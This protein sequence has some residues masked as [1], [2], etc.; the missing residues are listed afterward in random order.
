MNEDRITKKMFDINIKYELSW[1]NEIEQVFEDIGQFYTFR[2]REIFNLRHCKERIKQLQ[3]S[4]LLRDIN[5]KPKLRIY[6]EIKNDSKREEYLLHYLNKGK[7]SLF[8]QLRCGILPLA[9]ETGRFRK[10]R[11]EYR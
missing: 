8:A 9:V 5:N 4:V 6:K 11:C 1:A 10:K 7:R 3:E 2:N